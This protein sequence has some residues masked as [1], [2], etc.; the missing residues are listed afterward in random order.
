M[1]IQSHNSR[2]NVSAGGA[3]PA[4]VGLAK[5]LFLAAS[6]MSGAVAAPLT[7]WIKGHEELPKSPED[8]DLWLY[9]TVA[10][11]LVVSG[12]AFA[13]LTIA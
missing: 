5:I 2:Y 13:G 8:P 4:V 3:R 9:L 10:M 7:S 11:I 6:R 1:T 12:G